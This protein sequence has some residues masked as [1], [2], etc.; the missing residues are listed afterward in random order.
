MPTCALYHRVSTVDQDPSLAREELRRVAV[1]RGYQ[2]GLS[3]EET[4]SG[5]KT[6]RPGL[7]EVMG[8]ARRR[9]IDAVFV[10]KLDR[11]GRSL[12]DL[13]GQIE[14]LQR[15]GVRFVVTSQGFEVGAPGESPT[16][17]LLVRVM[18]AIAEFERTLISERTRLA[19]AGRQRRGLP[20]GRQLADGAPDGARVAALR[21]AGNSWSVVAGELACDVSAARRALQR[22]IHNSEKN[23]N[24][25]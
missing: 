14:E 9:E 1:A 6:N 2:V 4:G 23:A 16:G 3:V 13:L 20:H 19:I 21:V 11:F 7:L 25:T 8:A 17:E 24:E 10:W 5:A 18:G 22:H 15:L 12:L